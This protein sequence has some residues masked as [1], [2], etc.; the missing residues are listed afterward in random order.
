MTDQMHRRIGDLTVRI[1]R[2]RCIGS[3]NCVKLAPELFDLD[4]SGLAT[5]ASPA[6]AAPPVDR[7]RAIEACAVCPVQAL[8]VVTAAGEQLV[9]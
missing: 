1:D 9:P 8:I 5:F 3:G 4:D 2:T 7:T 6:D